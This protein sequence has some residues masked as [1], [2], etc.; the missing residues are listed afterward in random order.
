M[1]HFIDLLETATWCVDARKDM[2][3]GV[4]TVPSDKL[5]YSRSKA[6]N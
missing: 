3:T 5:G 2:T 6:A 1:D 4:H